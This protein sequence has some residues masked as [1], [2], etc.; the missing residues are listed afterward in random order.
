MRFKR[1]LFIALVLFWIPLVVSGAEEVKTPPKKSSLFR[2]KADSSFAETMILLRKFKDVKEDEDESA[3]RRLPLPDLPE[4]SLKQK[5]RIREHLR[6]LEGPKKKVITVPLKK[7]IRKVEENVPPPQPKNPDR[8]KEEPGADIK[9]PLWGDF[10]STE[11][12]TKR[13]NKSGSEERVSEAVQQFFGI[14]EGNRNADEMAP[15]KGKKEMKNGKGGNHS[16]TDQ[17]KDRPSNN[18]LVKF[19]RKNFTPDRVT[20]PEH[21]KPKKEKVSRLSERSMKMHENDK[22]TELSTADEVIQ[23]LVIPKEEKIKNETKP[24]PLKQVKEATEEKLRRSGKKTREE[25]KSS[26]IKS[27]FIGD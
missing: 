24:V 15:A 5:L 14:H 11:E 8:F 22:E 23:S 12:K 26:N 1:P 27:L 20:E 21:Q 16:G 2:E 19:I 9:G 18:V 25:G 6:H 4:A 13:K 17:A 10:D 3:K 7:R